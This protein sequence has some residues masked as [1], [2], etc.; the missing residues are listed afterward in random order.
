MI[1]Q[2]TFNRALKAAFALFTLAL[3]TM[4]WA[5][6][7]TVLHAFNGTAGGTNPSSL[8]MDASGNLYG[9]LQGGGETRC[10]P[11]FGCGAIFK[12]TKNSGES[13]TK[14]TVHLFTGGNDGGNP[15]HI[16]IDAKGN[17][18]GTATTGGSSEC[19]DGC[20]VVFELSPNSSGGMKETVILSF[21][22]PNADGG[23]PSS[24]QVDAAGNLYGVAYG[25]GGAAGEV[26]EL[27][28]NPGGS[29][30]ETIL[31]NFSEAE[32]LP[33]GRLAFD[34][35]GNLYGVTAGGGTFGHGTVFELSQSADGPWT[36]TI[37]YNFA[38]W[39]TDGVEPEG[40]LIIDA[41][42][43]LF[44]TTA[45]GGANPGPNGDCIGHCGTAFMMSKS[46][47][48]WTETVIANFAITANGNLPLA[49]LIM[50]AS[51]NLYGVNASGGTNAW[52][53]AFKLSPL[54]GG[55][56]STS[57]LFPFKNARDGGT[58]E[59]ALVMDSNGNLFGTAN[60]GGGPNGPGLANSGHGVV[61]QLT[62]PVN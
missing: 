59:G 25:F 36:E 22:G 3:A 12:L 39:P 18:F 41:A 17:I 23:E 29:W 54:S 45:F 37:I 2:P 10:S 49:P 52:G 15:S 7:E 1:S 24:V 43:N 30:T 61:F 58:P 44:G 27:S 40:G 60:S 26:F 8:V 53:T 19:F 46:G 5:D 16:T 35:S 57:V 21:Q 32:E 55:A 13:W 20:G 28:P 50:D 42:G 62:P 56:W 4:A 33:Q 11:P 51:G 31:H 48:T 34:K 38:G 14:S 6:K 9:V 47:G